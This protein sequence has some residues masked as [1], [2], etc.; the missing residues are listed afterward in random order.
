MSQTIAEKLLSRNNLAG[1]AVHAGDIVE[2][3][4]DGAMCH[5]HATEP[6]RD[7]ALQAGFKDGL[8]R[9]WDPDKIFVLLA[10]DETSHTKLNNFVGLSVFSSDALSSVAY[11]T[12]EIMASLSMALP[13]G[14]AAV[15]IAGFIPPLF[16]MSIPVALGI[17]ALLLILGVS[18]RQTI[19]A[20]PT[21][22]GAYIVAKANLG[23]VAALV[24]GAS[25]LTDYILTVAASVSSG[26][27]A[28]TAAAPLLQGHNVALTIASIIFVAMA[29][30]E[31]SLAVRLVAGAS[32]EELF[33][34]S[35]GTLVI[36]A[37]L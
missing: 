9:V 23:E 29:N 35:G 6:L 3:R 8:P 11:A 27:A 20:Y 13:H 22:G 24:A 10:S 14:V 4:I 32:S 5:Y 30:F 36:I 12:Q 34:N 21:G 19:L 2:A 31:G 26:V 7:L 33:F 25:L 37:H 18:Y 17:V 1:T 16:G 28:V 15:S